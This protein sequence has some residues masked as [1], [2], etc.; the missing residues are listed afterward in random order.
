MDKEHIKLFISRNFSVFALFTILIALIWFGGP[1]V[2][3][4][5][6]SY[7]QN[8]VTRLV[9][10]LIISLGWGVANFFRAHKITLQHPEK[11]ISPECQVLNDSFNQAIDFLNKRLAKIQV[12][13]G[14]IYTLPW[15]LVIG[16][17]GSGKSSLLA[18][19]GIRFAEA[20][21]FVNLNPPETQA[22]L[23][24][25]WFTHAGV[26]I[27]VPGLY[28]DQ[29]DYMSHTHEGWLELLRL[30]KTKRRNQPLNG[31]IITVKINELLE[32]QNEKNHDS[33]LLIYRRLQECL[34]YLK[35][36]FPVYII[37]THVDAL[38]GFNAYFDD[39]GAAERTHA[40]G[41]TFYDQQN[42]SLKPAETFNSEFD[43]LVK[44]LHERVLWRIHQER[45]LSKRALIRDFPL[46]FNQLKE[47]LT[48]M[49]NEL[50]QI[51]QHKNSIQFRGLFFTSATVNLQE[52]QLD[53]LF[54]SISRSYE[55]VPLKYVPPHTRNIPAY[56]I[57]QL[58]LDFVFAEAKV[59]VENVK[60]N[61]RDNWLQ[62]S[63]YGFAF[64]FLLLATIMWTYHFNDQYGKLNATADA[65]TQYKLLND[66]FN[67]YGAPALT[68]LLPALNALRIAN[69]MTQQL[70]SE[71]L[72]E[73]NPNKQATLNTLAAEV[74]QTQLQTRFMP[75]LQKLLITQLSNTSDNTPN[76][77]Y[78]SL[79]I[80]LMLSDPSHRDGP[81]IKNWI[82]DHWSYLGVDNH[83]EQTQLD[84][85]LSAALNSKFPALPMD[86]S[87][88]NNVRNILNS[89][90]S[91]TL[92]YSIL[93]NHFS[94]ST[95]YPLSSSA[96]NYTSMTIPNDGI[97]N[98]YTSTQFDNIY[99]AI[100]EAADTI[101]E[102]N[103][104]LGDRGNNSSISSD[105]PKLQQDIRLAYLN[106]YVNAWQNWLNTIKINHFNNL[107]DASS[108]LQELSSN[109]SPL[110]QIL[111]AIAN[112]TSAN[113]LQIDH[114]S[115]F[116]AA[117]IQTTLINHFQDLNDIA[118]SSNDRTLSL[119]Q[120]AM[121][122]N[123]LQQYIQNIAQASDSEQAAFS[124]AKE[125]MKG[126]NGDPIS[127]LMLEANQAPEPLKTWL[128]SIAMNCWQLILNNAHNYI[129]T[130]WQTNVL[131][132]YNEQLNN[133]YPLYI[134]ADEDINLSDFTNYFKPNGLVQNYF[135]TYLAPF[136][137]TT[138]VQWQW[139]NR[140]GLSV[141]NSLPV[142][143]Q[144]ERS[145][146]IQKMFFDKYG[147]LNINFTMQL[148]NLDSTVKSIDITINGQ[149]TTSSSQN[150]SLTYLSW[151]GQNDVN[152]V[153]INLLN[154]QQQILTVSED[155]PW[156]LF[157][158]L[159]KTNLRQ[160][161]DSEH[162]SFI[163]DMNNLTAKYSLIASTP[164]NPF[165]PGIVNQYRAP[166]KI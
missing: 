24:N 166:D 112:N 135:N 111:T 146:I 12:R 40:W 125:R 161:K 145:N 38:A 17:K 45:N 53:P 2:S 23:L 143:D 105:K 32:S 34:S 104:V 102:G 89:L 99:Q 92:A 36:D 69:N 101:I 19:S 95:I 85:H 130:Q 54:S 57:K 9:V 50:M 8:E 100:N 1:Y 118:L 144:F 156:A 82:H 71:W 74:Y 78:A 43:Q 48:R 162:F 148:I 132:V 80:Y 91:A 65:I 31:I 126:D 154:D 52:D 84:K 76:N 73:L 108:A 81:F 47:P 119:Q 25:W 72:F 98:I 151:P 42:K 139:R 138:G 33:I 149:K 114:F 107:S 64:G 46:Q 103:W 164:I 15:Y 56:F 44:R 121:T 152:N 70:P 129:N 94:A 123:Q 18:H 60:T 141:A 116:D 10:L 115:S 68:Q 37:A 41:I 155:G 35:C 124:A 51:P 87:V 136:V 30:L 110:F 62:L 22:T 97:S 20:Q 127:L 113:T 28:I 13:E 128:N 11:T 79:K 159:D 6:H 49:I 157:K 163:I 61:Y 165:I 75:A 134:N 109:N 137:D 150:T 3:I 55:L 158:V 7:L 4:A 29:P 147:T 16:T 27:D 131:A 140:D 66:N 59:A 160:D 14:A 93:D 67:N 122:L 142:L 83:S 117:D 77:L 58:L 96:Q 26:L 63:S 5:G 106:D 120:M 90:P 153:T 88:V 86:I 39:L 21:R 133:R